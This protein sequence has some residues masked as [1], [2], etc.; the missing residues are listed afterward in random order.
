M[1]QLPFTSIF[2]LSHPADLCILFLFISSQKSRRPCW[3][4]VHR[5]DQCCRWPRRSW[6]HLLTEEFQIRSDIMLYQI[7]S[8]TIWYHEISDQTKAIRYQMISDRME[9]DLI[10][11]YVI[12]DP[13][14]SD[15]MLYQIG[16]NLSDIK[17]YQINLDPIWYHAISDLIRSDLISCDIRSDPSSLISNDIRLNRIWFHMVSDQ[18]R[19]DLISCDIRLD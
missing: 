9:S 4:P 13:I 19:S 5:Q 7:G 6:A 1:F 12:S 3:L 17:W 14:R 15:F 2:K 8:D 18:I 16:P 10:S 11:Y